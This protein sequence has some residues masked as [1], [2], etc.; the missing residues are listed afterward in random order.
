MILV[1]RT[2]KCVGHLLLFCFPERERCYNAKSFNKLTRAE[3]KPCICKNA[4]FFNVFN[5]AKQFVVCGRWLEAFHAEGFKA[6]M[7]DAAFGNMV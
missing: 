6:F 2:A 3:T 5:Y 4:N 7:A 1:L